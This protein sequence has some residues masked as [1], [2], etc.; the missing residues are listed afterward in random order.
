MLFGS[1]FESRNRLGEKLDIEKKPF[2][3]CSIAVRSIRV[4]LSSGGCLNSSHPS[5]P[6]V[7]IEGRTGRCV[8]IR[9]CR[10]TVTVRINRVQVCV[11]VCVEVVSSVCL[12]ER[13]AHRPAMERFLGNPSKQDLELVGRLDSG[14]Q[15]VR[16]KGEEVRV[17]LDKENKS[18]Y[19]SCSLSWGW[20][21]LAP[22]AESL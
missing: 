20:E 12:C 21:L 7:G 8:S 5:I 10:L 18:C 3:I 1:F 15:R 14:G 4:I 22:L 11:R 16:L 13:V 9:S 2:F 6:F 19:S 17:S